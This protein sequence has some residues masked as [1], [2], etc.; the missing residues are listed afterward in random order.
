[1]NPLEKLKT[2]I[3]LLHNLMELVQ[4][5]KYGANDPDIVTKAIDNIQDALHNHTDSLY[6][7]PTWENDN[8]A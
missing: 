7:E 8:N 5:Y 6:I 1:M 3:Y 2:P 4:Y